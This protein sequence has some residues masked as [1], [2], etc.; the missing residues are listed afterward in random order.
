[1]LPGRWPPQQ[2]KLPTGGSS[3]FI[4]GRINAELASPAAS[5]G[6]CLQWWLSCCAC[7]G[8]QSDPFPPERTTLLREQL[9]SSIRAGGKFPDK[10]PGDA[11]RPVYFRAVAALLEESCDPDWEV[12]DKQYPTGVRLGVGVRMPRTPAVFDKKTKWKL[13]EQ[14][15]LE[16]AEGFLSHSGG[17]RDNYVSAKDHLAAVERALEN[18]PPSEVLQLPEHVARARYGS[19]LEVASFGALVKGEKEDGDVELR[20][21]HDA[22]HG[23]QVNKRIRLRDQERLPSAPDLKR[24]LRQMATLGLL[25]FALALDVS[26]AHRLIPIAE[27]DWPNLACQVRKGGKIYVN[28]VG[29]FGVA[30]ASYWWGRFAAALLRLLFYFA[31]EEAPFWGLVYAADFLLIRA[32]PDIPQ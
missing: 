19:A 7:G 24:V 11:D 3:V 20:L 4:K 2:R 1:M 32:G 18:A 31:G 16:S 28:K 8:L 26:T 17:W 13:K 5:S 10:R 23:V 9:F 25:F 29:T 14:E 21:L 12:F 22:T 6:K 15:L 30:S 27:E